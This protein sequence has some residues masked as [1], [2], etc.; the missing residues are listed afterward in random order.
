MLDRG[1]KKWTSLMMPEHIKMLED[2]WEE[3]KEVKKPI[4]SEDQKEEIQ[5][6]LQEAL[7]QS[8]EVIVCYYHNKRIHNTPYSPFS[9]DVQKHP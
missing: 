6:T 8:L 9:G 1:T 3:D 5:R 4:L 7:E 2:I